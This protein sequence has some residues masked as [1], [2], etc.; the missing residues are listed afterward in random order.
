MS[1]PGLRGTV[2]MQV[3][4]G[5]R[6]AESLTASVCCLSLRAVVPYLTPYSGKLKFLQK[7]F[8]CF[9]R[10]RIF[11]GWPTREIV[12]ATYRQA[13]V[14]LSLQMLVYSRQ[15][16]MVEYSS[17]VGALIAACQYGLQ[18]IWAVRGSPAAPSESCAGDS[19]T[20]S[21]HCQAR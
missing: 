19:L 8:F 21:R 1:A 3:Q 4:E 7:Q 5:R 2:E 13:E 18:Y 14:S 6:A 16:P 17:A 20:A 10:N 9:C 15:G 12:Q 11:T